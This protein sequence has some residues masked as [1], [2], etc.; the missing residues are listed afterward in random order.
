MSTT[1]SPVTQTHL[2]RLARWWWLG[3]CLFALVA[4]GALLRAYGP[5]AGRVYLSSAATTIVAL[6]PAG[7]QSALDASLLWQHEEA[8]ARH[9][10]RS[11][12]LNTPAFGAATASQVD[13]DAGAPQRLDPQ[14]VAGALSAT[15]DGNALRLTVRW[16]GP[17]ARAIASAAAEVLGT[18]AATGALPTEDRAHLAVRDRVDVTEAASAPVLDPAAERARVL[19]LASR[20]GAGILLALAAA[21]AAAWI[22]SR[23]GAAAPAR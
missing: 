11:G 10:A 8:T 21:A 1:Q 22:D 16:P 14:Q 4:V 2:G 7:E 5:A 19:D 13:R 20:L 17:Q 23:R 12:Y 3:A 9:L 6:P 15:H 18:E